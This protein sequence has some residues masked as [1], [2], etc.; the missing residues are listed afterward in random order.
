MAIGARFYKQEMLTNLLVT[1]I[2]G[3]RMSHHSP[4]G[5]LGLL[6]VLVG[7]FC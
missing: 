3:G 6:I 1:A 4:V 2:E 7:K 5:Y